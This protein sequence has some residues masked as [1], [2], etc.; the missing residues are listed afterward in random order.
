VEDKGGAMKRFYII[1][2]MFFITGWTYFI[3][4]QD[5]IILR[6]GNSIEANVLE[7]SPTEIRYKRFDHLEGPTI[8]IMTADV[9]SIRYE[10]G[11]TEII[12]N[13]V[14]NTNIFPTDVQTINQNRLNSRL[15]TIGVMLGYQGV[16]AFGFALNGTISP[17]NYTFFDFN[18]GLGFNSFSFNGRVNFNVYVPFRIG[19]WYAGAGIGGG[20]N[21][22][23]GGFFAGNVTTGFILFNWLNIAYTLQIGTFD[24]IVNHNAS[25]GYTYRFRSQDNYMANIEL[26]SSDIETNQTLQETRSSNNGIENLVSFKLSLGGFIGVFGWDGVE[27]YDNDIYD[28]TFSATYLHIINPIL[29]LRLLF[30]FE[31]NFKLGIGTDVAYALLS[32]QIAGDGVGSEAGILAPYGIIGYRNIYLHLGYDFALGAIYIAPNF[33]IGEHFLL[34][35]PISLFGSNQ[36]ISIARLVEPPEQNKDWRGQFYFNTK[37]FQVG[38]FLQYVF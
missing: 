10:N 29:S 33:M 30:S 8:V 19:G 24:G 32:T 13:I 7:I 36:R 37:I 25:V 17:L 2:I 9:L 27:D 4:A 31:N 15:N 6:D 1:L 14:Q 34:G 22:L 5:L 12:N 28:N 26:D 11:R 16:S 3:Y 38:I 35:I 20:Y 18:L 21:E 23:L